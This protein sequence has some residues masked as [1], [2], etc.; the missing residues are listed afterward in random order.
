MSAL[1]ILE[2]AVSRA[3][4]TNTTTTTGTLLLR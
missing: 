1:I 2:L 3:H 4:T